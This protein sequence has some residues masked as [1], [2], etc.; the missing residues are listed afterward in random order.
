MGLCTS[1][2][3]C[4][5]AAGSF[6][7]NLTCS[8]VEGKYFDWDISILLSVSLCL[9]T[10]AGHRR[11]RNTANKRKETVTRVRERWA[12]RRLRSVH[13]GSVLAVKG[14]S[15]TEWFMPLD[16]TSGVPWEQFSNLLLYGFVLSSP[17]F[18]LI[19]CVISQLVIH[20]LHM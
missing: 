10:I 17:E 14:G 4:L 15:M 1:R 13:S 19:M 11:S 9:R 5:M 7:D 2:L 8:S 3:K 6:R 18:K 12:T 20:S 16:L